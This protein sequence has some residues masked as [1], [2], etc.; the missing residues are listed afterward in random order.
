MHRFLQSRGRERAA[1]Q[2]GID[3]GHCIILGQMDFAGQLLQKMRPF[4]TVH[5]RPLDLG[6]VESN[7]AVLEPLVDGLEA[8]ER[9]GVDRVR[10]TAKKSGKSAGLKI[11]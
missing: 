4:Q 7:S 1:R 3:A 5:D 9:R 8:L 6:Q 10:A 2:V 11:G